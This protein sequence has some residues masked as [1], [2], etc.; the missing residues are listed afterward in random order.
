MWRRKQVTQVFRQANRDLSYIK[1]IYGIYPAMGSNTIRLYFPL[2]I[3]NLSQ[4][5][6]IFPRLVITIGL[7]S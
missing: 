1:M 7:G 2:C 6:T 4:G 5:N 3:P